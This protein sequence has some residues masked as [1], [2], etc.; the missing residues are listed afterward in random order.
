MGLKVSSDQK[1]SMIPAD[2]SRLGSSCRPLWWDSV[3]FTG[4]GKP[5]KQRG[6]LNIPPFPLGSGPE[7]QPPPPWHQPRR[8]QPSPSLLPQRPRGLTGEHLPSVAKNPAGALG[9]CSSPRA[10]PPPPAAPAATFPSTAGL[11]LRGVFLFWFCLQQLCFPLTLQRDLK[12]RNEPCSA[13][14]PLQPGA[15]CRCRSVKVKPPTGQVSGCS[16]SRRPPLATGSA[17]PAPEG[18]GEDWSP[19][20]SACT[21]WVLGRAWSWG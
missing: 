12:N 10:A 19:G 20:G 13:D 6:S 15:V 9:P 21:R 1:G 18:L 3:G 17:P 8:G 2:F 5:G 16:R 11:L 7:G 4:Q 14:T